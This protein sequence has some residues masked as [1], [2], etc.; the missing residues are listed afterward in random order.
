M[1]KYNLAYSENKSDLQ[2]GILLIEYTK[3]A[4]NLNIERNLAKIIFHICIKET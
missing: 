4:R 1:I 3:R 2:T